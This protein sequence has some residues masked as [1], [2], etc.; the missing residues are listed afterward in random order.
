MFLW[1]DLCAELMLDQMVASGQ[2]STDHRDTV[3]DVLLT[4]HRHQ[5]QRKEG[6]K[7]LP[8]IRSLADIGHRNS[9]KKLEN[10]GITCN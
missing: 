9:E 2:L 1:V 6:A 3:C 7:G 8:M 10:K 5:H 4:R